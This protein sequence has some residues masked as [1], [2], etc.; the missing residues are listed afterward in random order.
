MV[1]CLVLIDSML[2]ILT[3]LLH[4]LPWMVLENNLGFVTM[5]FQFTAGMKLVLMSE[6]SFLEK[7]GMELCCSV[8]FFSFKPTEPVVSELYANKYFMK[9]LKLKSISS[10]QE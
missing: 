5:H 4:I 9:Y 2:N 7:D 10:L 6:T 1:D 3:S 8:I